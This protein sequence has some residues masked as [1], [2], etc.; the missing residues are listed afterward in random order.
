MLKLWDV[1]VLRVGGVLIEVKVIGGYEEC[2]GRNASEK[3]YV[4]Q[5]ENGLLY[6]RLEKEL[7]R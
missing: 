4:F 2:Y 5:G 6:F 7:G 3:G 1:Y